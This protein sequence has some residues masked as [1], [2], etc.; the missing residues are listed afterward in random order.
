MCTLKSF[1][2][3]GCRV[4]WLSTT[5]KA[6]ER[7]VQ[8]SVCRCLTTIRGTSCVDMWPWTKHEPTAKHLNLNSS[9]SSDERWKC[10]DESNKV[11]A[12]V[13]GNSQ[14]VIVIEHLKKGKTIAGDTTKFGLSKEELEQTNKQEKTVKIGV[15]KSAL[16][17]R[18]CVFS[19]INRYYN[20][21]SRIR[22]PSDSPFTLLSRHDPVWVLPVPTLENLA[23]FLGEVIL[24]KWRAITPI[25]SYFAAFEKNYNAQGMK[26]LETHWASGDYVEK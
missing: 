23:F 6:H 19:Q 24:I 7:T 14:G 22:L 3:D 1:E 2:G 11:V 21:V 9:L 12:T 17:P 25:N 4:C 13:L 15:Q 16:S 10:A 18:Q 20:K 8:H 5:K 26:K